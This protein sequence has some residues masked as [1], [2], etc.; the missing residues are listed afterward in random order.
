[1]GSR[2][3]SVQA[4]P[5]PA[6]DLQADNRRVGAIVDEYAAARQQWIEKSG[7]ELPTHLELKKLIWERARKHGYPHP[8]DLLGLSRD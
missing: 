2:E 8:R 4:P 7:R 3:V 6:F 1:M 5:D